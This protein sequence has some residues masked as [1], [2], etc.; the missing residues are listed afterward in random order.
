MFS[1]IIPGQP[2]LTNLAQVEAT[3]FAITFPLVPFNEVVVFFRP[4]AATPLPPSTV[5]AVYI[6]FPEPNPNPAAAPQFH[7]LG[8]LRN[9][10]QSAIFKLP[11]NIPALQNVN[12][13]MGAAEVVLGISVEPEQVLG[14]QLEALEAEQGSSMVVRQ[15]K[16]ITT[17][18][19]AQRIIGNAFNFL[20]SFAES[21]PR[22]RGQEV[23][24]LKSFRDWWTK[25]ERK[26]DMDPTF[27]EREDPSASEGIDAHGRG[28]AFGL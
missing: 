8:A 1:V 13:L 22:S 19:L 18:V 2:C 14:P 9:D 24:S 15:Q 10:K 27:L 7:L 6:Q 28:F 16:E 4:D 3:K 21:D 17:K 11:P 5:A 12:A 20:A 23:V 25:F 26:V